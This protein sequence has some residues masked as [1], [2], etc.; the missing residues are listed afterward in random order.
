VGK[1]EVNGEG[2]EGQ[3]WWMYFVYVYG[4]RTI[5]PDET[6]LRRGWRG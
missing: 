1:E 6:D 3:L 2:D 5:E 4:N